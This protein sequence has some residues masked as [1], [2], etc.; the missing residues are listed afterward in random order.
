[1]RWLDP[2]GALL[3]WA[4]G[5]LFLTFVWEYLLGFRHVLIR[6]GGA[7]LVEWLCR[8]VFGCFFNVEIEVHVFLLGPAPPWCSA[9][10][11]RP[12]VHRFHRFRDSKL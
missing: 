2:I 9:I 8:T 12:K 7:L 4:L 3:D 1:M 5:R 10:Q 11:L 6:F